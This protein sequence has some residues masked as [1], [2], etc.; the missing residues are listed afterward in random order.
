MDFGNTKYYVWYV[1]IYYLGQP[2]DVS[3]VPGLSIWIRETVYID[4]SK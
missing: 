1:Q 4:M 2:D 3:G